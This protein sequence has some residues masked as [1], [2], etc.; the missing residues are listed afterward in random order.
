MGRKV[1]VV[2]KYG[3]TFTYDH[4]QEVE[5]VEI[6]DG[7]LELQER[8]NIALEA[9]NEYCPGISCSRCA[10]EGNDGRCA[11]VKARGKLKNALGFKEA[12]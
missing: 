9:L 2:T 10:F 5:F 4:D 3:E 7:P 11:K 8:F 6:V 1:K 12:S